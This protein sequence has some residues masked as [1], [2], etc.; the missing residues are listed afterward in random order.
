MRK[1]LLPVTLLF[2]GAI[3]AV[4]ACDTKVQQ[5]RPPRIADD[6][7]E[8]ALMSGDGTDMQADEVEQ[9]APV[10]EKK[11]TSQEE[12]QR[13]CCTQCLDGLNADKSGDDPTGIPCQDF[14]VHVKNVCLKWFH[15][16]PMKASEAQACVDDAP[17]PAASSE[18]PQ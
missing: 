7:S 16:N 11:K 14:T 8:E 9:A 1:P 2:L 17:P 10:E 12:R 6:P 13:R 5:Q 4:A 3:S 15:A 18:S